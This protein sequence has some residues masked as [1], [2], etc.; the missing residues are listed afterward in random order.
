MIKADREVQGLPTIQQSTSSVETLRGFVGDVA[1]TKSAKEISAVSDPV[2]L[3]T[4]L[5]K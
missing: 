1:E 2:S 3:V 5:F 4:E